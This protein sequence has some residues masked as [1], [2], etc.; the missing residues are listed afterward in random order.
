MVLA[1]V[2]VPECALPTSLVGQR[3]IPR[4]GPGPQINMLDG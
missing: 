3:P 4:V 2:S 1:F